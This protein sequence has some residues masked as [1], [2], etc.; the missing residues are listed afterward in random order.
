M[1]DGGAFC[2]SQAQFYVQLVY[3]ADFPFT[4]SS[5]N[6]SYLKAKI[7]TFILVNI[8]VRMI[9]SWDVSTGVTGTTKVAPKF[10]GTYFN[11]IPT[12]AQILPT[13]AT[14]FFL[15]LRPYKLLVL[16]FWIFFF[17]Y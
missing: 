4:L 14:K 9:Q 8:L 10:S 1:N 3:R 15:W 6:P 12:R 16:L 7:D 5:Q 2:T 17:K 11:P 13:I